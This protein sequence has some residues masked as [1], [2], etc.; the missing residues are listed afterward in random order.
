MVDQGPEDI[1]V[2]FKNMPATLYMSFMKWA[3]S[4]KLNIRNA[5]LAFSVLVCFGFETPNKLI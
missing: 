4:L 2:W 3:A 5:D 1:F